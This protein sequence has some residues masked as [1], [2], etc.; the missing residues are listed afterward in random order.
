VT[1][2][3]AGDPSDVGLVIGIEPA[4]PDP[5]ADES[6]SVKA[7]PADPAAFVVSWLGGLCVHEAALFLRPS[8]STYFLHVEGRG[9]GNCP[10]MAVSRGVRITTSRPIP[11]GSITVTG[12]G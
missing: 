8:G 12:G 6:A 7:D 2:E 4:D 9:G 11:S 1:Q 5:D 10:A 3:A